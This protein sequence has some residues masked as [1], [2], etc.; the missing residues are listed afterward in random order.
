LILAL[1]IPF[2]G[3][4]RDHP[5]AAATPDQG[6]STRTATATKPALER[7]ARALPVPSLTMNDYGLSAPPVVAKAPSLASPP[8][9][10]E[11]RLLLKHTAPSVPV[12]PRLIAQGSIL[13][14]SP[15]RELRVGLGKFVVLRGRDLKSVVV[16]DPAIADVVVLSSQLVLVTGKSAGTTQLFI[17]DVA[18]NREHTVIV[19]DEKRLVATEIEEALRAP[20]VKVSLVKDTI[21]LEGDVADEKALQRAEQLAKL[22]APNVVN[23]LTVQKKEESLESPALAQQISEALQ[24]EGVTVRVINESAILSGTVDSDEQKTKAEQ[25]AAIYTPNVISLL[26]RKPLSAEEIQQTIGDENVTV[27]LVREWVVLEGSVR[28]EEEKQQAEAAAAL[29]GLQV[30]NRLRFPSTEVADETLAEQIRQALNMPSVKVTVTKGSVL[31]T[32]SVA[33]EDEVKRATEL[34][35]LLS[36]NVSAALDVEEPPQVRVEVKVLEIARTDLDHFGFE[37]PPLNADGGAFVFGE[38]A[39]NGPIVRQTPATAT[40]QAFAQNNNTRVLS[41]PST[42]VRSGKEAKINVGGRIPIP[43]TSYGSQGTGSGVLQQSVDW[44]EFGVILTVTPTV[45]RSG[46]IALKLQTEVSQP[47]F[48]LAVNIGGGLVPGFRS[49]SCETDVLV[50]HGELLVIGGLIDRETRKTVVKFP[51]LGDL[52]VLGALFR[53]TRYQEGDTELVILVSPTQVTTQV[54]VAGG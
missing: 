11:R 14:E 32:G 2:M 54:S 42:T 12:P 9:A 29:T 46:N 10:A 48:S 1:A 7:Q 5:N 37:F 30:L 31:L 50:R 52:P 8:S 3:S 33:G 21:L 26:K 15:P 35:K 24:I 44:Q 22:F 39:A 23:L 47:D 41:S 6:G 51:V 38:N 45:D 18:E 25:V 40:L 20:G 43:Q 13:H 53:S 49:R 19:E 4:L 34:A 16:G 17:R 36:P 27:R 28:T